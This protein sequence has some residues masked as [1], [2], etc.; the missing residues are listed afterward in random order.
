[1]VNGINKVI[2]FSGGQ[3]GYHSL[4]LKSDGTVWAWGRNTEGQLGD[5][6]IINK[7]IPTKITSLSGIIAIAGGEYHS[8]AIKNDGTVWAWGRNNEGQQI[9]RAHV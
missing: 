3:A 5:G 6:T 4:A 9:G 8:F 2:A 7:N 1:M